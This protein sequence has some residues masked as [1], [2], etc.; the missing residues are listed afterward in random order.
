MP[1]SFLVRLINMSRSIPWPV[2]FAL[3][4][5]DLVMCLTVDMV[6]PIARFS[7]LINSAK[8]M[9]WKVGQG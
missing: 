9:R 6:D 4:L 2:V 7:D 5:G 1:I 8:L 3:S